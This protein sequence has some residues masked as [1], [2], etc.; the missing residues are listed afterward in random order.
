MSETSKAHK[1]KALKHFGFAIITVSSSR[2]IDAKS[3]KRVKD[4]TGDYIAEMVQIAGH[5]VVSRQLISDDKNAIEK[6]VGRMLQSTDIDVIVTCGGTGINPSDV[7]I[8]TIE[9]ILEK[10][11]PGFG[12]ILRYLSYEQIGSAAVMTRAVAGVSKGKAI[13]C[14]PGSPQAARACLETLILPESGHIILHARGS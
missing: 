4:E 3:G 14:L 8:E 13:F 2:Y 5:T 7:T 9:P 10:R 6:T 1:E 12:E 11:L